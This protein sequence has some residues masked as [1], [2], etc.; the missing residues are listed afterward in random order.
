MI[1]VGVMGVTGFGVLAL[2]HIEAAL[3]EPR[4]ESFLGNFAWGFLRFVRFAGLLELY[5]C[6]LGLSVIAWQPSKA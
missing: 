3:F 4:R 1:L 6:A 5:L 2:N